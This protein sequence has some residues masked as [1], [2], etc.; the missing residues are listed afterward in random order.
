LTTLLHIDSSPLGEASVTRRLTGEFVHRW[1]EAQPATRVIRRDLQDPPPP[2]LDEAAL[3][4]FWNP[5]APAGPDSRVVLALSDTM[6]QEL[7]GADLVVLGSPM[8]NFTVTST[9][10]AWMDMVGR[11]GR[12]FRYTEEGVQGLLGGRRAVVIT[13]RGGFYRGGGPTSGADHQTALLDTYFRFL[14]MDE[15][16]FVHA[17]GQGMERE[18]ARTEEDRARSEIRRLVSAGAAGACL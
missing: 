13:A 14:G 11:A 7:E 1:C 6:I 16:M 15:V 4:A 9:L 10:K 3:A 5:D 12:T 8:Y 2:H 18:R 17:E